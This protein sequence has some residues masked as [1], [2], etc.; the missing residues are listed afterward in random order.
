[1]AEEILI[2][3]NLQSGEAK[4]KINEVKKATDILSKSIDKMTKSEP[5]TLL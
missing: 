1:M 3:I 4:T 2:R 5:A